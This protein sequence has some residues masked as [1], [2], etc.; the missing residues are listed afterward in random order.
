VRRLDEILPL[1]D[2]QAQLVPPALRLQ[3]ADELELVVVA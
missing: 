1:R 3:L 2:E